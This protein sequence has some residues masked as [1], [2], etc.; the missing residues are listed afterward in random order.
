MLLGIR[1]GGY[2]VAEL[3]AQQFPQATLLPVTCRRPSTERK[4]KSSFIK[5]LLLRLPRAV[6]DRLR[7]IEHIMLTQLRPPKP[8]VLIPDT[9]ELNAIE[10]LLRQRGAANILIV[11]DAVD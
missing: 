7:I 1:S 8:G 6:N 2:V 3:M 5:K 11:D 4:Q 10:A 9:N